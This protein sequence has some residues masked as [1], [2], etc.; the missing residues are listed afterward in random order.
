[1]VVSWQKQGRRDLFKL[2]L[3]GFQPLVAGEV[4]GGAQ[5]GVDSVNPVSC[6]HGAESRARGGVVNFKDLN[7]YILQLGPAS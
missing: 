6:S 4:D 7:Y 2:V 3:Q 5:C 1:M